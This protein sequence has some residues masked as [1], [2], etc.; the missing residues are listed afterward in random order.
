MVP[1][2]PICNDHYI[3]LADDGT[4]YMCEG[5]AKRDRRFY[6][7]IMAMVAVALAFG[8]FMGR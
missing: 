6:G 8:F 3:E 4:C 2:N 1:P 7:I 5:Q